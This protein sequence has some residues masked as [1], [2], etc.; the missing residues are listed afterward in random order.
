[1]KFTRSMR[2]ECKSE[3]RNEDDEDK[4]AIRR[5]YNMN[6]HQNKPDA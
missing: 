5:T 2:K 3:P 1:M 6:N 4:K